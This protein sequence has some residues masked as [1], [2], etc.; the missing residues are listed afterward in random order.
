MQWVRY[1]E[2]LPEE[3][4]ADE[5]GKILVWHKH[6]GAMLAQW[7]WRKNDFTLCWGRLSEWTDGRW[8]RKEERMPTGEDADEYGCILIKDRHGDCHIRVKEMA[9]DSDVVMWARLPDAPEE[10]KEIQGT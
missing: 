5:D 10:S 3:R 2:R 1:S 6:Q 9:K 4:D 7:R 8:I